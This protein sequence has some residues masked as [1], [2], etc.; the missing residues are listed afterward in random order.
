MTPCSSWCC[1]CRRTGS[2]VGPAGGR[3]TSRTGISVRCSP[4][5]RIRPRSPRPTYDLL[6]FGMFSGVA[7]PVPRVWP[8]ASAW[9]A[10]PLDLRREPGREREGLDRTAIERLV[11]DDR[12][13]R[14]EQLGRRQA[15]RSPHGRAPDRDAPGA[16]CRP[17]DLTPDPVQQPGGR[18][19]DVPS[20]PAHARAPSRPVH[21]VVA[22]KP[23]HPTMVRRTT[24]RSS[25]ANCGRRCGVSVPT[26]AP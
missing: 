2:A 6:S 22:P 25:G 15:G 23:M 11:R 13:L 9:I 24:E 8:P 17:A 1:C 10:H 19:F 26:S 7:V 5:W 21:A 18:V 4:P 14:G 16:L 12:A 3:A 20:S